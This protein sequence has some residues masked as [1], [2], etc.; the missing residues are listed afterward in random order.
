MFL[1]TAHV[2]TRTN[3]TSYWWLN[4]TQTNHYSAQ[5]CN[6]GAPQ[7]NNRNDRLQQPYLGYCQ[8]CC[9][10]GHI[11]KKCPSYKLQPIQSNN[12]SSAP[13]WQPKVNYI[14]TSSNNQN[15]LLDSGASYH[16]TADLENMSLHTPYSGS[17]DMLIG[18]G[19]KLPITHTGSTI[20][21]LSHKSFHLE[22]VLGV[23][24]MKRNLISIYQFFNSNSTS[25]EFILDGILVKDLS[26]RTTLLNGQT[27]GGVYEWPNVNPILAFS[28]VKTTFSI[29]IFD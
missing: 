8:L 10:Q 2:S 3:S 17:D 21:N 16:V 28:S 14:A 15:W 25:I 12:G 26:R 23:S 4:S 29:G 1:I 11:A 20:P 7:H 27:K 18:D 6:N 9:I 13:P 5:T 22:N 24:S 19:T